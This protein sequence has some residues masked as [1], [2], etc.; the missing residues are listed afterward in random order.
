MIGHMIRDLLSF[1][2][3]MFVAL[4]GF[5]IAIQGMRNPREPLSMGSFVKIFHAY[6]PYTTPSVIAI[7]TLLTLSC[8]SP[9]FDIVGELYQSALND[10]VTCDESWFTC[11]NSRTWMMPMLAAAYV[12]IT[13]ILMI[14]LLIGRYACCYIH[15]SL[16]LTCVQPC[17]MRL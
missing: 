13:N 15:H 8:P 9:E 14:N 17:S 2:A 5:G 10:E 1:I 7:I 3:F 12:V 6:V 11:S 4:V 16:T